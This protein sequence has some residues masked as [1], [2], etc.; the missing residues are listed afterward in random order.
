MCIAGISL[1]AGVLECSSGVEVLSVTVDGVC[2]YC[3]APLLL[4]GIV[5]GCGLWEEPQ[6]SWEGGKLAE[7]R[8]KKNWL[9]VVWE[10]RYPP[11]ARARWLFIL[12]VSIQIDCMRDKAYFVLLAVSNASRECS[13][14]MVAS[15]KNKKVIK[16]CHITLSLQPV[17]N[18]SAGE[19]VHYPKS[20]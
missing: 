11:G 2:G 6:V 12:H 15:V 14:D 13:H 17:H 5:S 10:S 18:L 19:V 9:S 8:V 1:T 20:I 3:G 16:C 4:G 7:L